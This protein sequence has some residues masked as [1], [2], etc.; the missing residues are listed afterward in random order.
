MKTQTS[1]QET[2]LI[3]FFLEIIDEFE[4]D[5][6]ACDRIGFEIACVLFGEPEDDQRTDSW[7]R[8]DW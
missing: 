8:L 1:I 7:V 6:L 4:D 3:D 2:E 5:G